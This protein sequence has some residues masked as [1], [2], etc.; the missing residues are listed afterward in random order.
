MVDPILKNG[1][2]TFNAEFTHKVVKAALRNF[3]N[4]Y[5]KEN[6]FIGGDQPCIGD[7]IGFYDITMLE[8]LD[9]D[10]SS[11]PK[12]VRWITEMRKIDGVQKADSKFL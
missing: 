12:I 3:E 4:I 1:D 5:L 6:K 11:Y 2:P 9:Y 8:V 10:F 7:L